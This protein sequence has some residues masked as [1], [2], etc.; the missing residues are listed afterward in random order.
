[1]SP[2][3]PLPGSQLA[4]R[5]ERKARARKKRQGEGGKESS[6]VIQDLELILN[7]QTESICAKLFAFIQKK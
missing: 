7:L 1:M 3:D 6:T 2:M 5:A 4:G